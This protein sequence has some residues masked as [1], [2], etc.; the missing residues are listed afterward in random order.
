MR[1]LPDRSFPYPAT[2]SL[3]K[4][5]PRSAS[6]RPLSAR[7]IASRELW[8]VIPSR[9]ANR[10]SHF[11]LKIRI[12]RSSNLYCSKLHYSKFSGQRVFRS[13]SWGVPRSI[14]PRGNP[15]VLLA[16]SAA[17][18]PLPSDSPS[19]SRTTQ[20]PDGRAQPELPGWWRRREPRRE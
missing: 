12:E 14:N 18:A 5:P 10:A 19:A 15:P 2:R 17:S 16:G 11:V 4:P 1:Y 6:T 3:I 9:R 13:R 20:R 8:S 7:S